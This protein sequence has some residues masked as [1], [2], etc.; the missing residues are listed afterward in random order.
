MIDKNN[1]HTRHLATTLLS[2]AGCL[3]LSGGVFADA[4]LNGVSYPTIQ[5][6]VHAA[7]PNDVIEVDPG[8]YTSGGDTV[9]RFLGKPITVR[10]IGGPTQTFIDGQGV[11]RGV[12]MS[13]PEGEPGGA[14]LEGFTIMN[15]RAF[16]HGGGVLMGGR[17]RMIDCRVM[18]STAP[19][20]GGV[21]ALGAY[22][23]EEGVHAFWGGFQDVMVTGNVSTSH[24][25][26]VALLGGPDPADL[27]FH[28]LG[29]VHIKDNQADGRGGGLYLDHGSLQMI[30]GP[31][32]SSLRISG[33]QSSGTGG[34]LHARHSEVLFEGNLGFE[35]AQNRATAN[36]GGC[37]LVSTTGIRLQNG[38]FAGNEASGV[39]AYG[40]G[41]WAKDSGYEIVEVE[42]L[43]N[44]AG[45]GGGGIRNRRSDVLV[46][47]CTFTGNTANA[48]GGG[49]FS[50]HESGS[51]LISD[52]TISGNQGWQF[53]GG[54]HMD[55]CAL[56]TLQGITIRNNRAFSSSDPDHTY[57][58][59]AYL[60]FTHLA[61]NDS[62]W[63]ENIAGY[64]GG[65]YS[66]HR[67]SVGSGI[68]SVIESDRFTENEST[69]ASGGG[70]GLNGDDV[71][72]IRACEF[73]GNR[74]NGGSALHAGGNQG[75]TVDILASHFIGN[76][77]NFADNAVTLMNATSTIRDS[78]FKE[79]VGGGVRTI[80]DTTVDVIDSC[81]CNNLYGV[82]NYLDN[83]TNSIGG[84]RFALNTTDVEGAWLETSLNYYMTF[85]ACSSVPD[86]DI[87]GDGIVD[88][89]DLAA[90]LGAW[91]TSNL[92]ADLNE[93]GVVNGGDLA[94]LLGCWN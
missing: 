3:S 37:A 45:G 86:C 9:V 71:Y 92:D 14:I 6:A 76:G 73:T 52:S 39:D 47:D 56:L 41:L 13:A 43:E 21:A 94:I 85:C 65:L 90:L 55:D 30:P 12:V 68:V 1:V 70:I 59:G 22:P 34:G 87:N 61:S 81:F 33:N 40:G 32:M 78:V 2:C 42:F 60:A 5:A 27:F 50:S 11:R 53:G 38:T 83:G 26:G 49:A 54:I 4:W 67:Q 77:A 36:G 44:L 20:G 62:D 88:G 89:T 93:D 57:G 19:L 31:I 17:A 69:Y 51:T 58:G 7:G 16:D 74:S 23:T 75:V 18:D 35:I 82:S 63:S 28:V 64:G 91:G 66:T 15:G 84:C 10:A 29:T 80:L 79:N 24:G 46:N 72:E 25:G 8:T 48:D